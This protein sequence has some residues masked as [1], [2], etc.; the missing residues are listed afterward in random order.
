MQKKDAKTAELLLKVA[1]D[2]KALAE[3][4]SGTEAQDGV[5]KK[6]TEPAPVKKAPAVTLEKVRGVLAEKSRDGHTA[7]VRAIIQKYG[8]ERLSEIDPANYAAVLKD[9]EVIGNG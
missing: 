3:C 1:D 5:E 6:P 2:L 7:E 9:A 4:L 8:A